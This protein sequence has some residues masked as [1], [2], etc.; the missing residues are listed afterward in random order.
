MENITKGDIM[1]RFILLIALSVLLYA[2]PGYTGKEKNETA[3]HMKKPRGGTTATQKL[4]QFQ[5]Q[6]HRAKEVW[7]SLEAQASDTFNRWH[8]AH[9]LVEQLNAQLDAVDTQRDNVQK[10]WDYLSA[11][12]QAAL[13][14]SDNTRATF[15]QAK[16]DA[17]TKEVDGSEEYPAAKALADAAEKTWKDAYAKWKSLSTQ[18]E[19]ARKT[20][21]DLDADRK[22]LDAQADAVYARNG[23]RTIILDTKILERDSAH[24]EWQQ[25]EARLAQLKEAAAP[26]AADE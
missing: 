11:E 23:S 21:K 17:A 6:V 2:A 14:E 22:E 26:S 3:G 5:A 19:D 15:E 25:L 13:A 12:I 9:I 1:K 16:A 24:D 20:L 10:E 18:T 8:E 7:E 4:I